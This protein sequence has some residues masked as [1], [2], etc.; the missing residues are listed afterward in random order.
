MPTQTNK[1][2]HQIYQKKLMKHS[3]VVRKV[4]KMKN[5]KKLNRLN[6]LKKTKET[7]RMKRRKK[8]QLHQ[9]LLKM[10]YL[11]MILNQSK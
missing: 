11:E 6:N 7:K 4:E 2:D 8:N 5:Q 3:E 9:H 1:L 10:I